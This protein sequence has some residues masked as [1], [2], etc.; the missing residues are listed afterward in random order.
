MK[1]IIDYKLNNW[2]D[3]IDAN[4][5]NKHVGAK[6]KK[7]EMGYITYFL[8]GVPKIT[9]YPIKI[10]CIWH[11]KNFGSDL[12]N[13]SIKAVLDAMQIKG[14]L[15]NDN[16]S[17]INEITYKVVKDKKDYLEMMIYDN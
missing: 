14:I 9:R 3:I 12:D 15:E 1:I 6:E 10:E 16:I 5:R 8:T 17:H 2:N 4:R 13:K 11:T 7:I